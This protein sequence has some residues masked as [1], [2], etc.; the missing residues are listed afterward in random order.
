MGEWFYCSNKNFSSL[1]VSKQILYAMLKIK[2]IIVTGK[3]N[4]SLILFA[5]QQKH[6][7]HQQEGAH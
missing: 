3:K 2:I 5:S 6:T 7:H 4:S 1:L